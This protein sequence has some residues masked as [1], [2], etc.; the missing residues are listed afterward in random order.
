MHNSEAVILRGD[1]D[2]PIICK[3]IEERLHKRRID[4]RQ[5]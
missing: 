1:Q 3:M 5:L 4:L 2:M